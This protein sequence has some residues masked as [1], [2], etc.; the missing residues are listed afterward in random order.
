MKEKI[1][2]EDQNL[3]MH[4]T[5]IHVYEPSFQWTN[6]ETEI[7]IVSLAERQ[8]N[9]RGFPMEHVMLRGQT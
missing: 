7:V 8:L 5:R 4:E 1:K 6:T 2:N 9:R 3:S